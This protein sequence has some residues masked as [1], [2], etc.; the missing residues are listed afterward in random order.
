MLN[1]WQFIKKINNNVHFR[2]KY[3]IFVDCFFL[4]FL[5]RYFRTTKEIFNNNDNNNNVLN[6]KSDKMYCVF[7]CFVISLK[8]LKHSWKKNRCPSNIS[9]NLNLRS[10]KFTTLL[11]CWNPGP[12]DNPIK[13]LNKTKMIKIVLNS[14]TVR[15]CN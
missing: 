9:W 13:S 12:G 1:S 2:N 5:L 3:F 6:Q 7:S 14:L 8:M 11:G 4:I 10:K 15:Y